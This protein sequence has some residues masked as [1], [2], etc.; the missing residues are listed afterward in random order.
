M[1]RLRDRKKWRWRE[2]A[3][4]EKAD[5]KGQRPRDRDGDKD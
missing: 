1:K 4:R 2:G 3:K 5:R